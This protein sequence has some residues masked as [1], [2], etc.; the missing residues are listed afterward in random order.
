MFSGI[1]EEIGIVIGAD[2]QDDKSI[3]TIQVKKCLDD[4]VIGDSVAVNG[5]CL[6]VVKYEDASFTFEAMP[7]T[8]R[9]TNLA[10]LHCG[11][12]I[13]VERSVKA[14]TRIGGHMVQGHVDGTA[15]I[16]SIEPDGCA[17]KIWFKKPEFY[18][19]C[20]IPKGFIAID[21]MS[22]TLVDVTQDFF[23]VCFIPHTQQVT[24]VQQYRVGT[25]VNLEV[26]HIVKTMALL[27]QQR[28][29]HYGKN[30]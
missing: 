25:A 7:E 18:K 24:V 20:F 27:L 19:D 4:V 14:S 21:G 22:L 29:A 13:N 10:T 16:E 12:Q 6:T 26:D 23:S 11:D 5:A 3:L 28:E 15:I 30:C 2:H 8:L 17:L 9:L 1:V